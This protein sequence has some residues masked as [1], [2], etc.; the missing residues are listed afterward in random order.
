[1]ILFHGQVFDQAAR[2]VARFAANERGATVVEY[3][4]IGGAIAI[5]IL[6]IM[7]T[8][9]G[10]LNDNVYGAIVNAMSSVLPGSGSED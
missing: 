10:Q 4:L 5:T 6:T 7:L 3:G 2:I 8:I 9:G 1:M